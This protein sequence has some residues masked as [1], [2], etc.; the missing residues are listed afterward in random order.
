MMGIGAL[1][2]FIA[3]ILVAAI[4]ASVLITT[5]GS[6]QQKALITGSQTEE[7]V[8]A[9]LEMMAVIASDASQASADPHSIEDFKL[10]ARLKSGSGGMNFNNSIITVDTETQ[11][12]TRIYGQT[13]S[14][15]SII[16]STQT[17]DLFYVQSGTSHE[18]GYLNRGDIVNIIF[19]MEPSVME[20]QHI[21]IK[22]IPRIGQYTPVDFYTPDSMTAES[23][24][25]W[26]S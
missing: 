20:N 1:I 11:S 17:F 19:H 25:L 22:I 24:S 10:M 6:L 13:L 9:G 7:G 3:V 5:G 15:D 8:V 12:T 14:V 18:D 2:I 26:P 16:S 23:V 21:S 4:A